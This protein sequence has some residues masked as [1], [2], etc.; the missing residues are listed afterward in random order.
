MIVC[1]LYR[2][3][4]AEDCLYRI[5]VADN[6]VYRILVADNFE[7]PHHVEAISRQRVSVRKGTSTRQ[8]DVSG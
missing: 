4:V 1:C 2:I 8:Y 5:L 3:L 7:H 6:F